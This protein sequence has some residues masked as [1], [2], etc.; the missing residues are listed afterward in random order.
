MEGAGEDPGRE[1]AWYEAEAG[2]LVVMRDSKDP[3]GPWLW[4]SPAAWEAFRLGIRSGGG[5]GG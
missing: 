3:E 4:V 2:R 1:T 5:K